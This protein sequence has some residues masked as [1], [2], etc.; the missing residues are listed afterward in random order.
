M[1]LGEMIETTVENWVT[2]EQF[3]GV[4]SVTTKDSPLFKQAYGFAERSNGRKNCID[5]RFAI[6][7]GTKYLTALAIGKLIDQGKISFE[8][9]ASEL[10]SE[11]TSLSERVTIKHLLNHTSGVYDYLDEE[12]IEDFD[13]FELPISPF[14][15]LTCSD[16]LPMLHGEAKFEAGE[17]F[18]YSN[19][20]YIILGII[21]ERLT[22]ISFQSFVEQQIL[23]PLGMN[24]SGFFALNALPENCALH[25]LDEFEGNET[26]LYKLP[27][28]GGSDGGMFTTADDID[29]LWRSALNG[30]VLSSELTK[31]FFSART[32]VEENSQYGFG[33]WCWQE[34]GGDPIL[35]LDGCDAGVG[36]QSKLLADGTT[37]TILTNTS[38][39]IWQLAVAI[40]E[41]I[42]Q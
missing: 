4:V 15:L 20:G 11:I 9:K 39:E 35:Y 23:K 33:F 14:K 31:L 36:F 12:L 5:T 34:E 41:V 25:Y 6:A 2:K 18:A 37:I 21:I 7:S 38:K 3:S 19:S 8:T 28:V 40:E 42:T 17:R 13:A 16:Y 1:S 24:S 29:R 10:V 27:I 22:G 26:N 32:A 30:E